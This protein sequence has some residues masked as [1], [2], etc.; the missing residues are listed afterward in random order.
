MSKQ[1]IRRA[2]RQVGFGLIELMI[3]MVLGLLVLG[4]AIA[5]FQSNQRTFDANEGTNRIQEGARVAYEL[6]SKDIRAA[7]GAACSNLARPDVEHAFTAEETA[8]LT[9][10]I[11]G[12]GSEFTVTSGDDTA[13]Q[14]DSATTSTIVVSAGQVGKL[15]DAFT[16]GDKL[17]I[18]NANAL[19]VVTVSTGGVNDST[20]TLTFTPSTP[21][22]ITAD[23]MAPPTT[24]AV[25]RYRSTR[26]YLDSGAL[27]VQRDGAAGQ[28]VITGVTGLN[29]SYLSI[30]GNSYTAT[31]ANWSNVVAVRVNLGLR[32]QK[33]FGGD[34]KVD[35]NNFINRTSTSVANLRSRMP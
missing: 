5:V 18:C 14:V 3:S 19:Y 28:Q 33:T 24:V 15:S 35:G 9:N 21:L 25:A 27:Y 13:Y 10:F 4:A 26:W 6:M 23:P 11:S 8:L 17:V 34:I 7:G 12:S 31:P 20:R 30:G 2:S 16:E 32:G 22:A 29:V 1:R